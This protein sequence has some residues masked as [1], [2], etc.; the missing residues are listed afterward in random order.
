MMV[1]DI[2]IINFSFLKKE[3]LTFSDHQYNLTI[4]N[5]MLVKFV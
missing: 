1:T 2:P 4:D 3:I 5:Y